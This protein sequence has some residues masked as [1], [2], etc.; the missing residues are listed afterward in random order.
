M[1]NMINEWCQEINMSI[2]EMTTQEIGKDPFDFAY[3]IGGESIRVVVYVNRNVPRRL[4][5]NMQI[6]FGQSQRERTS[7]MNEGEWND[8]L[9]KITD[10]LTTYGVDWSFQQEEHQ[11]NMLTMFKFID[12]SSL[13]RDRFFQT[14]NR[15]QVIITQLVR[16]LNIT[17]GT[18]QST[19]TPTG[20]DTGSSDT[21]PAMYG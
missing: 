19:T 17:L 8:F 16:F 2:R 13:D 4:H 3:I 6:N 10:R 15:C 18:E 20:S 11:M 5:F 1:K 9:L 21:G 12:E 7:T 14:I